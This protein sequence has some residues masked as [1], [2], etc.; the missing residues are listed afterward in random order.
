MHE[1]SS[2]RAHVDACID[3]DICKIHKL[4]N[5]VRSQVRVELSGTY[6]CDWVNV[7]AWEEWMSEAFARD[8]Q[9]SVWMDKKWALLLNEEEISEAF[10]RERTKANVGH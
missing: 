9:V 1:P 7:L 4:F 10:A 6:L 2:A 8:C 3:A 5:L